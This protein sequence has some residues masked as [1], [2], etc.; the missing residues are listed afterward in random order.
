ME[1]V[2]SLIEEV[3]T[4]LKTNPQKAQRVDLVERATA[5]HLDFREMAKRSLEST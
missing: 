4:I 1:G 5:K 2:K 3:Q